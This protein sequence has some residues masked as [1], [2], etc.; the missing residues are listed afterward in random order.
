MDKSIVAL[1]STQQH[2]EETTSLDKL[3]TYLAHGDREGACQFAMENDMWAHALI[4]SQSHYP[5][6]F[7][8]VISQFIKR[9]LVSN[10]VQLIPQVPGD[11][12]SLCMLYSVFSGAGAD[13]GNCLVTSIAWV[14]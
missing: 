14:Q 11:K 8:R 3:E 6:H 12:K 7:K 5:D 4:I 2:S 10:S 9:E 1:L 13:A